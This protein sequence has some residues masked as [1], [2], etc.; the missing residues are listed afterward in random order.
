MVQQYLKLLSDGRLHQTFVSDLVW[1]IVE[2]LRYPLTWDEAAFPSWDDYDS[3]YGQRITRKSL[4]SCCLVCR[5]WNELFTPALYETIVIDNE[6]MGTYLFQTLLR[7]RPTHKDLIHAIEVECHNSP[8]GWTPI[9]VQLPNLRDLTMHQFDLSRSH[10]RLSRLFRVL[11]DGC[12]TWIYGEEVFFHQQLLPQT[13]QFIRHSQP[14]HFDLVVRLSQNDPS[15]HS[16]PS[17]LSP[18]YRP[19]I[20]LT[21]TARVGKCQVDIVFPRIR[22]DQDI[23]S[24]NFCLGFFAQHLEE[25]SFTYRGSIHRTLGKVQVQSFYFATMF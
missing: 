9:L 17:Q 12:E 15:R 6:K 2:V 13:F 3:I 22:K 24:V 8:H 7:Y 4:W 21:A 25:L 5:E 10:P 20:Y 23:A 14:D 16:M 19:N 1:E 11:P 18:L